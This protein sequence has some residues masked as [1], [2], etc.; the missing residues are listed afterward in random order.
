MIFNSGAQTADV[1]YVQS[2]IKIVFPGELSL[3]AVSEGNKAV[4]KYLLSKDNES[5]VTMS[6]QSRA[7]I[8]F[9]P[10][11]VSRVMRANLTSK[12]LG[13]T[14]K[15]YFAA[16]LEYLCAEILEM[17]SNISR[18]DKKVRITEQHTFKAITADPELSELCQNVVLMGGVVSTLENKKAKVFEV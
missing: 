13:D 10:S 15:V 11:R 14:A 4:T 8:T 18:T 2:A 12:R 9:P 5:G 7:G 3:H 17:S 16:A 6:K 1:R